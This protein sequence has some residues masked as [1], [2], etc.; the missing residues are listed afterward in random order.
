M[1]DR[2]M[3]GNFFDQMG[4][5]TRAFFNRGDANR[6]TTMKFFDNTAENTHFF[7]AEYEGKM[8]GYLFLWDMHKGVP[9]LGIA[10]HEGFKGKGI[11]RKLM[12]FAAEHARKHQKGGILL[13]THIANMRGQSLYEGVGY[14]RLGLHGSSGEFLYLLRL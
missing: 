1:D 14:E 13:T 6:K 2:V 3:V 9:W 8:L 12:N 10:V 4:A 5:E 11:G 7:L